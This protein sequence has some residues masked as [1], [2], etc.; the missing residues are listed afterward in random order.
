MQKL[1]QESKASF[2]SSYTS[3]PESEL[4]DDD[5]FADKSLENTEINT[6][7]EL[8]GCFP[9]K[10]VSQRDKIGYGKR[11]SYES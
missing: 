8:L 4:G 1:L 6:S 2:H 10:Y 9:I 7:L 11:K 5:N 3:S